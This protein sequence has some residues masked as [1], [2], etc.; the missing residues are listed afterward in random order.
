MPKLE[1]IL[2]DS[3][4]YLEII[5]IDQAVGTKGVNHP[6]DVKI[7]KALFY[8]IPRAYKKGKVSSSM[9]AIGYDSSWNIP[10]NK[11]PSPLDG[12]MWGIVELTKSFQKY[13]NKM[14][15]NYGYRVNVSGTIKPSN[16]YA[17]VGKNYSTIAALNVFAAL[18]ARHYKKGYIN[19]IKSSYYG[20]FN[21]LD[22]ESEEEEVWGD[23]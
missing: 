18:G 8:Y 13:A 6:D 5:N 1:T 17:L 7:V 23:G 4:K 19:D 20:E 12:T 15:A 3:G 21:Y 2:D 10:S 16:G 9:N 22:Y 11:I 14:L